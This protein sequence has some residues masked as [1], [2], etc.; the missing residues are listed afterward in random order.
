MDKFSDNQSSICN[1]LAAAH[2]FY[3]FTLLFIN[4]I[5]KKP[6]HKNKKITQA[7]M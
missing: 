7:T 2:Y 3:H 4:E 5:K 1:M 6:L